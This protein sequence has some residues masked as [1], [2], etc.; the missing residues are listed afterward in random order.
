MSIEQSSTDYLK[1]GLSYVISKGRNSI[2]LRLSILNDSFEQFR[3]I[4]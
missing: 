4:V 3:I 1:Y 2:S